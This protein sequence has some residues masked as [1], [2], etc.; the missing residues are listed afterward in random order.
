MMYWVRFAVNMWADQSAKG[1][2]SSGS[3]ASV[4]ALILAFT[5][6]DS[7]KIIAPPPIRSCYHPFDYLGTLYWQEQ[8]TRWL[9]PPGQAHVSLRPELRVCRTSPPSRF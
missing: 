8:N 1:F 3:A 4:P 6:S 9:P 7:L 5:F 2:S